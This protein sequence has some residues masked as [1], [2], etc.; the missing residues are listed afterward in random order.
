MG[1]GVARKKILGSGIKKVK[2]K[3]RKGG[4]LF[5]AGYDH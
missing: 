3:K 2:A 4:A 5:A 1:S